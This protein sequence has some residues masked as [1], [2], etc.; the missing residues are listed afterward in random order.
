MV[1][2]SCPEAEETGQGWE[3]ITANI[4]QDE[5]FSIAVN[6]VN[7]L[8]A[9]AGSKGALFKTSDGGN[10]WQEVLRVRG[11]QNMVNFV[12]FDP[13]NFRIVYAA[14]GGGLYRSSDEGKTWK[15]IFEGV[16]R[17]DKNCLY[18]A[19]S[20]RYL[21]LGTQGGLFL[22]S[23]RGLN[24]Q[25]APGELADLPIL[26]ITVHPSRENIVYVV[27]SKGVYKSQ[28]EGRS[29]ERIYVVSPAEG[30]E[31]ESEEDTSDAQQ[32]GLDYS[33]RHLAIDKEQPQ[34]IFLASG[35]GLIYSPDGG[36]SWQNWPSIGLGN[37]GIRFVLLSKTKRMFVATDNGIFFFQGN[38]W[39]ELYSGLTAK[40]IYCL[41]QDN[42]GQIW[43]AAKG[44]LF[45]RAQG[46][47]LARPKGEPSVLEILAAEPSIGEIQRVAIAY[48]EVQPEKIQSWRRGAALRG[49]FPVFRIDYDK[50]INYDSGLD[51]YVI[52]PRD[53]E[54]YLQWDLA[55]LIWNPYQKDID[56]RSRLMVQLRDDILDEV[57]R[58]YFERRRLQTELLL[59][60]PK[61]TA[62]RLRQELRLQELTASI[63]ALTGGYLSK[64]LKQ[65][66]NRN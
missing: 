27:A 19:A 35:E 47:S 2:F 48:A 14:T 31:S 54:Y 33:L 44:G 4:N 22:S 17:E 57:T 55:D 6:P 40:K 53:W 58:L 43:L 51:E 49:L 65:A 63:D 45:R 5:F 26:A 42:R 50:T 32:E 38:R 59:S 62:E 25:R 64:R 24:W 28:D 18:I 61:D 56:V 10:S 36:S 8:V 9:Y 52:G 41:T 11:Q 7:F 13:K 34:I 37:I 3:E 12:A 30:E 15:K 60:P 20:F 21:Y 29:W 1:P 23:D 16:G 46:A 66:E 39:Q